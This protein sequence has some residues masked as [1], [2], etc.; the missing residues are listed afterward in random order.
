MTL[1]DDI[2]DLLGEG[3]DLTI[4]MGSPAARE[5]VVSSC[6]SSFQRRV[7][8][9]DEHLKARGFPDRHMDLMQR[10]CMCFN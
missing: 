2:V 4:R 10:E 7:V 6:I 3:I 1:S 5:T 8:A 9:S